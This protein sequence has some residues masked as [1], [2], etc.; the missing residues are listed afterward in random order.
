MTEDGS[1][2]L[3]HVLQEAA[4][5][6]EGMNVDLRKIVRE[7]I[8]D[9]IEKGQGSLIEQALDIGFELPSIIFPKS[10]TAYKLA[11]GV[12]NSKNKEKEELMS[13]YN[14]VNFV[15]D[16]MSG[17]QLYWVLENLKGEKPLDRVL[18]VI[19]QTEAMKYEPLKYEVIPSKE[20]VE[21]IPVPLEYQAIPG[22]EASKPTPEKLNK[23]GNKEEGNSEKLSI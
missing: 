2:T 7:V 16:Y 4:K 19:L 23:Q 15:I 12:L 18:K 22:K 11:K 20:N 14:D 17:R 5:A 9:R 3:F 1:T 21:Y 13:I 10:E 6:E 8:L